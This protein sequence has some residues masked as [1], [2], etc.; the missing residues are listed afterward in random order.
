MPTP[1]IIRQL[2]P[3]ILIFRFFAPGL[4]RIQHRSNRAKE[5]RP[6]PSAELVVKFGGIYYSAAIQRTICGIIPITIF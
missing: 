4:F 1:E 3:A 5:Y 6:T 2:L